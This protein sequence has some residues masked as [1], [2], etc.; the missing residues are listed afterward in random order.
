[1]VFNNSYTLSETFFGYII[2]KYVRNEIF[3]IQIGQYLCTIICY[4]HMGESGIIV[5][6]A[7][8]GEGKPQNS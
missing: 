8:N 6:A 1:M 3:F 2:N 7:I 4:Y 5:T